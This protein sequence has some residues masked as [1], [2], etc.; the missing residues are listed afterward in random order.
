MAY[1]FKATKQRIFKK[2][3]F[4][5]DIETYND[6]KN[7]LLASIVGY[8]RYNNLYERTFHN[9]EDLIKELKTNVI[10]RNSTLFATNLKFD[11][12]G[13]F[14][15]TEE[16]GNFTTPMRASHLL[17]SK[18]YFD[19]NNFT[20]FSKKDYKSGKRRSSLEFLDSMN[21][22][23]LS[24]EKMG[25]ELTKRGI[26]LPKITKP[27][28]GEYPKTTQEMDYMVKYNLRDSWITYHFMKG[29]IKDVESIGGT[30]KMT[31]AS[32][33]MSLFKN[34]YLGNRVIFQSKIDVLR[35]EFEAYYGGR[36]ET[37]K[38]GLFHNV[39]YY[40]FNSL[41]PSVMYANE[42]P[43]P[44][45]QRISHENILTYIK[46]FEG[47]SKVTIY[48]PKS[49]VQPLPFHYNGRMLFP[50]GTITGRW[51]H[52]EL[53]NAINNGC[54]IK[55][56]YKTIY[57]T[58][59]ANPFKEFVQDMYS[60]RVIFK[61]EGNPMEL[62]VKLMMNSL[63]GKF[64]EKFDNKGVFVHR[65][66]ITIKQLDEATSYRP[67]GD[68]YCL[69]EDRP[70]KAHCIP[71]WAIYVTSYAR[72]KL[73][74][75]LKK[76]PNAIYCDTDSIITPDIIETSDK[77]GDLKL[78]QE[79]KMGVTIRPK[80][81][82]FENIK[83]EKVIRWKGLGKKPEWNDFFN[84]KNEP[85]IYYTKFVT[86][87]TAIKKGILPNEIIHTHKEFSLED[88]KRDWGGK[89]FSF[90]ELQGSIPL[91]IVENLK[92]NKHP[93]IS[94]GVNN[95]GADAPIRKYENININEPNTP[96]I[97]LS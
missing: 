9:R 87:K 65:D 49:D 14:F 68:Y 85:I 93:I 40:D 84:L 77:L 73:Y 70:P 27:T 13:T 16:A 91:Q 34:K 28:F 25:I 50:Y 72:L 52:I 89:S 64:G 2:R 90:S 71:I 80:M 86:V 1:P 61:Q 97:E 30:F 76:H 53:R 10:F 36:T 81:Y 15:N 4:G 69:S 54:I 66:A 24:V 26:N 82:A 22:V 55:K 45:F 17:G 67:E 3:M 38:R 19:G 23:T 57:Y 96:I 88:Q 44:N 63:Y 33:T 78:E 47:T 7:F 37:F 8:D 60:K 83:N 39:N 5:F 42:Y 21:Y 20:A 75:M 12:F 11:F 94:N 56:V 92:A 48:I 18:T 41:Y 46:N 79:I 43:D 29:F 95:N 6:N 59:M 58:K 32:T 62:V 51:S 74:H 31:I 35:E